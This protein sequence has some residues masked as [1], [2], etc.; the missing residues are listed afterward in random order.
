MKR[1][2]AFQREVIPVFVG[3]ALYSTHPKY[4]C[5]Y[6]DMKTIT[7]GAEIIISDG[8]TFDLTD[9]SSIDAIPIPNS[10]RAKSGKDIPDMGTT[11]YLDYILRMHA[12][13]RWNVKDYHLAMACLRK[14]TQL[15]QYSPIGWRK[16]DYFRIV[17]WYEQLGK[18]GKAREWEDW[19]NSNIQDQCKFDN[20]SVIKEAKSD[21]TNLVYVSWAGSQSTVV[22][23]YQARV[24]C[25]NGMDKR[26]PKLP[27]FLRSTNDIC[28][29][30][31]YFHLNDKNLDAI[32][33]K[34]KY[35]PDVQASWR[36]FV[37][38][39][40]PEEIKSHDEFLKK[41][42][43]AKQSKIDRRLFF[44]VKYLFPELA[45]KSQAAFYRLCADKEKYENFISMVQASDFPLR[46]IVA[47]CVD[48]IDP[49]PEYCGGYGKLYARLKGAL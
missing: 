43:S 4:L 36:P 15:M 7:Y 24:Y 11:G 32:Y 9:T 33:Y 6:N 34:D 23:K 42:A 17:D 2:D 14:A 13:L 30:S 44:R 39:R 49:E 46:E 8:R 25:I 3:G 5:D 27:D 26:F 40:S 28:H 22:S 1:K 41:Q 35:L 29:I 31:P 20:S 47:T 18:F 10:A 16:D 48:P 37:D 21:K 12:S 38:D 19:I 45:P